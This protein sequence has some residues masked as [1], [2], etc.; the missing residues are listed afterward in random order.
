LIKVFLGL[1]KIKNSWSFEDILSILSIWA[2]VKVQYQ[3]LLIWR[4]QNDPVRTFA[5]K[6]YS[7]ALKLERHYMARIRGVVVAEKVQDMPGIE[8]MVNALN[9]MTQMLK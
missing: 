2:D 6:R 8:K 3:N 9:L 7:S 1:M 5:R 4:K